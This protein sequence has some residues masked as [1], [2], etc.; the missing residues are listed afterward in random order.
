[1]EK[2]NI[3]QLAQM[4]NL[5]IATVSKALRDS[6]D[7]SRE[8]KEKVIELA[9]KLNYEPNPHASSLRGNR[10][11]TIAVVLPEIANN[12]FGL[13]INGIESVAE[14]KE[15]HV[16]IYLT[17]ERYEKE[18]IFARHLLS[19]RVDG[20]LVSTSCTTDDYRHLHALQ[21]KGVPVVYF[22]RVLDDEATWSVTTDDHESSY[23]ATSHLIE[24]GCKRIA[25]FAVSQYTSIGKKR[26]SGYLQALKD[27][28]FDIEESLIMYSTNCDR[29]DAAGIACIL[30]EKKC[31]GVFAAIEKYAIVAYEQCH[32][33]NISIPEELKI[34]AFSNL[35]TAPLLNPS[36]TTITQPAFD[37]GREAAAVLFNILEKKRQQQPHSTILKSTLI[38]RASTAGK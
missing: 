38:K 23:L 11:K 18:K 19:G 21:D 6:Y 30:S 34:I 20:V 25:H 35:H 12:Y 29:E 3:K 7:I 8:T 15:F 9:N 1:M 4:L 26:L 5:S 32:A 22:D 24:A 37:I 14:A 13:V 28:D 10:S 17:H 36:L 16:L 27:H 31:D 33:L 2:V